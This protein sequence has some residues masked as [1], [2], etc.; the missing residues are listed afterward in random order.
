ME[1]H[2]GHYYAFVVEGNSM[3]D[4]TRRSL[5]AG[6][7]LLVRELPRDEWAPHLRFKD[8]PYWVVVWD[9][10][11]RVKQITAQDEESG[12]ITLHSLNPSPEYCDFTLPLDRITRLF[13]VIQHKPQIKTFKP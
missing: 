10:N 11:V 5:E 2:H 8:W 6:D 3:D 1:V 4:G 7:M 12:A 9:N 13:N